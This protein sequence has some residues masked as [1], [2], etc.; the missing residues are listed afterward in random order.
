MGLSIEVL[1]LTCSFPAEPLCN[2]PSTTSNHYLPFSYTTYTHKA[3]TSVPLLHTYSS[4]AHKYTPHVNQ[5]IYNRRPQSS[6]LYLSNRSPK[7]SKVSQPHACLNR[8]YG[9]QVSPPFL[10]RH[11]EPFHPPKPPLNTPWPLEVT[12]RRVHRSD[13]K[14]LPSL[15]LPAYEC[16]ALEILFRK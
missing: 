7:P 9:H 4:S 2:H 15:I 14:D 11:L 5:Y 8:S 12:A 13:W 1:Y 10:F 3:N 6:G 16:P